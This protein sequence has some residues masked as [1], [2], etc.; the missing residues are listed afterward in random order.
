VGSVSLILLNLLLSTWRLC[1]AGHYDVAKPG[2]EK[3][4]LRAELDYHVNLKSELM[5]EELIR[6]IARRSE[7]EYLGAAEC[8]EGE[9]QC[10]A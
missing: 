1:S 7:I 2:A 5:L 3:D 9:L 4:R 10:P 8:G 6:K